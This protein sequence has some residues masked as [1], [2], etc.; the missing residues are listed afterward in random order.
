LLAEPPDHEAI[1]CAAVR[2]FARE[3]L[4]AAIWQ[5]IPGAW[6][7]YRCDVERILRDRG[8]D[9]DTNETKPA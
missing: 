6:V 5:E 2:E 1:T 9:L 8:V 4:A 3:V 7:I